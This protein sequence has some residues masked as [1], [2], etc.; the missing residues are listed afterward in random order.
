MA[1]QPLFRIEHSGPTAEQ[2]KRADQYLRK[3][4]RIAIRQLER[5][6]LYLNAVDA[7]DLEDDQV[8]KHL[9]ETVGQLRAL[10]RYLGQRRLT[11]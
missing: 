2:R 1:Q 4:L 3:N 8:D 9:R 10:R 6:E 5:A 7:L 11:A